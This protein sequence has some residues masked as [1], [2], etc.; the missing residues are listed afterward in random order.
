[1]AAESIDDDVQTANLASIVLESGEE[2]I[3]PVIVPT[4]DVETECIVC[5]VDWT[6]FIVD[7]CAGL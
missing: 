1:M 5:E 2:E 6:E 7:E 4:A 3:G